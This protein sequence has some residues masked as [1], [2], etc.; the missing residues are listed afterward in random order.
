MPHCDACEVVL[1]LA[2]GRGKRMGGPKALMT[3]HGRAWWL[4]QRERIARTGLRDLWVVSDEVH[5]VIHNDGHA[6]EMIITDATAPMFASI[7]V[8]LRALADDPPSAVY[9][10]PVDVPMCSVMTSNA[11][12]QRSDCPSA[13]VYDGHAGHPVRLPWAFIETDILEQAHDEQWVTSARLDHLLEGRCV[14]VP[15]DDP[16]VLVNLNTPEVLE[17]WEAMNDS[18]D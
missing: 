6:P 9:V 18:C 17:K 2:A 8:G 12:R 11:L 4:T 3:V 16:A 5:N 14:H 13:P 1:V 10:L 15:V 7:I